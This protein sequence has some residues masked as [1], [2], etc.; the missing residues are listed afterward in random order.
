MSLQTPTQIRIKD[1]CITTEVPHTF[2]V[3]K[4][5]ETRKKMQL[6]DESWTLNP[7]T[8]AGWFSYR[9]RVRKSGGQD[10]GM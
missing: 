8:Q 5:N 3:M 7:G 2:M 6:N 4:G 1:F 10:G 9:M